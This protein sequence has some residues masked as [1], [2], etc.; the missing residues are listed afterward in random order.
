MDNRYYIQQEDIIQVPISD[1]TQTLEL[2]SEDLR[3]SV[4]DIIHLLNVE[5]VPLQYWLNVALGYIAAGQPQ[6]F[7]SVMKTAV[8]VRSSSS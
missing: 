1:G 4:D 7:E 5:R 6:H 3:G 2:T 8:Q